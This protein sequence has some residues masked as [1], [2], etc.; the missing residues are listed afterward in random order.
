[1]HVDSP[2][3]EPVT[4]SRKVPLRLTSFPKQE[5]IPLFLPGVVWNINFCRLHIARKKACHWKVIRK[6]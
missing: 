2:L 4:P 1:M 5:R 6:K 3:M